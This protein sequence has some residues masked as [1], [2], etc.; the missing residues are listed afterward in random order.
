VVG[1]PKPWWAVHVLIN[2]NDPDGFLTVFVKVF[3][4]DN[5][6]PDRSVVRLRHSKVDG[7][8]LD[9]Q[10]FRTVEWCLW[11]QTENSQSYRLLEVG[12]DQNIARF[13][14]ESRVWSKIIIGTQL[15][16]K[17]FDFRGSDL[18]ATA[19]TRGEE[20]SKTN[21]AAFIAMDKSNGN[22]LWAKHLD[23]FARYIYATPNP[24]GILLTAGMWE[25]NKLLFMQLN[26]DA[27]SILWQKT[28]PIDTNAGSDEGFCVNGNSLDTM[29]ISF[30]AGYGKFVVG[31]MNTLTGAFD[32]LKFL[33]VTPTNIGSETWGTLYKQRAHVSNTG[34]L[35]FAF[36]GI[37]YSRQG[38]QAFIIRLDVN[39]N[40]VFCYEI[41]DVEDNG[42]FIHSI[43]FSQDGLFAFVTGYAVGNSPPGEY[44]PQYLM[45]I[46]LDESAFGNYESVNIKAATNVT[47]SN[48]LGTF[49]NS[50]YTISNASIVLNDSPTY[51]IGEAVAGTAAIQFTPA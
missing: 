51:T 43:D 36:E 26:S 38:Q 11:S 47:I 24:N 6:N 48:Y 14:F 34:Q 15:S 10:N 50:T 3:P 37:S 44:P 9:Q 16:L 4:T 2:D 49:S 29:F 31:K 33:D 42:S 39:G 13:V 18:I 45:K 32:Y 21:K 41:A 1:V 20:S 19:T 46:P 12:D 40:I 22:L 28:G 25:Q 8:Q 5:A 17:F 35:T 7:W 30:R 23:P 27:S